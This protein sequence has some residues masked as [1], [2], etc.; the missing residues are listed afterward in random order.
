VDL[1]LAKP[2]LKRRRGRPVAA[3]RV[4]TLHSKVVKSRCS[5]GQRVVGLAECGTGRSD[6]AASLAEVGIRVHALKLSQ[7]Q[8]ASRERRKRRSGLF[9]DIVPFSFAASP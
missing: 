8:T 2:L 3:S 1:P 6:Q 7:R 5:L 9:G 4:H